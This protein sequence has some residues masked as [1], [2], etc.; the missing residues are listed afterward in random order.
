MGEGWKLSSVYTC[1]DIRHLDMIGNIHVNFHAVTKVIRI[2]SNRN[3]F[4]L[5]AYYA[6]IKYQITIDNII[7]GSEGVKWELEFT[8]LLAG[9]MGFHELGLEFISSKTIENGRQATESLRRQDLCSS[10]LGFSQNLGWEIGR[11]TPFRTLIIGY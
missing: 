9:K 11:G 10:T 7:E 3:L 4:H 5:L 6:V 1:I 2:V 8:S